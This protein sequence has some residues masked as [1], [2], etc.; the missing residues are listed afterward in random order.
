[1]IESR[2]DLF[3]SADGARKELE[4]YRRDLPEGLRFR[5]RAP[6]G[7]GEGG[8]TASGHQGTGQFAV[9]FYLLAWREG[10]ITG[11]LLLNGFEG[12]FKLEQAV[13]LAR[14]QQLRIETA[15]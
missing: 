7:L 11:S 15:S 10:D 4:A 5:G 13:A 8:F 2:V 6:L 9:R 12:K 14:K 1:M 3:K